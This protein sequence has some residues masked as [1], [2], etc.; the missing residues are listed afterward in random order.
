ME[1]FGQIHDSG[2]T[3]V[4]VTHEE[5][6]AKFTRRVIRI[7]DGLVETDIAQESHH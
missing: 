2:N 1:L 7:R 6:V 3:V 4:L 5:D